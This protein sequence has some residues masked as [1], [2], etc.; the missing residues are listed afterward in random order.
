MDNDTAYLMTT[1]CRGCNLSSLMYFLHKHSRFAEYF[2]N[3]ETTYYLDEDKRACNDHMGQTAVVP[4]WVT[5]CY[6][7]EM[8]LVVTAWTSS[9]RIPLQN[10]DVLTLK[11]TFLFAVLT[12]TLCNIGWECG[13][14]YAQ[15]SIEVI[16]EMLQKGMSTASFIEK[17]PQTIFYSCTRRSWL[18]RTSARSLEAQRWRLLYV[19]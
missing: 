16:Y 5:Q 17:H 19:A 4:I 12:S 9:L 11:N 3:H 2:H 15:Q 14:F 8:L 1:V 7:Q 10:T 18:N 6:S 13:Y